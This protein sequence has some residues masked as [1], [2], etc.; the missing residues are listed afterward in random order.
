ML[1]TEKNK[2][3]TDDKRFLL[4]V[5]TSNSDSHVVTMSQCSLLVLQ[6]KKEKDSRT[7]SSKA[8]K[9]SRYSCKTSGHFTP[10]YSI[11]TFLFGF[12]FFERV[13]G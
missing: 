3:V 11:A 1:N 5:Q 2:H 13:K 4:R 8:V 10:D 12:Y 6:M 7:E 9:L